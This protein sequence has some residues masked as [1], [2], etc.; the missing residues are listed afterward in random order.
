MRTILSLVILSVIISSVFSYP[1]WQCGAT[2][3]FNCQQSETCCR[4]RNS[5]TGWTCYP[6]VEGVCCSDGFSVCPKGTKCNLRDRTCPP[7]NTNEA[8]LTMLL[9]T[10]TEGTE[11]TRNTNIKIND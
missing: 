11:P 10:K 1:Y 7:A 5:Q 6:L 4:S 8:F 2:G 9:E 3:K